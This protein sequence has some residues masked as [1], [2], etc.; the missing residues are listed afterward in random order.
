MVGTPSRAKRLHP[1]GESEPADR[2][3]RPW[4][5]LLSIRLRWHHAEVPAVNPRAGEELL[6]GL[7][8]PR[9]KRRRKSR[10]CS[11]STAAKMKAGKRERSRRPRRWQ[12]PGGAGGLITVAGPW[13][14][15]PRSA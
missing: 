3:G 7:A 10:V 15:S 6:S 14:M 13:R 9:L 5:I 11:L 4:L 1:G 12:A 8:A 2:R